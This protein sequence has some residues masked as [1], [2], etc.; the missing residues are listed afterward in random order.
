MQNFPSLTWWCDWTAYSPRQFDW[1]PKDAEMIAEFQDNQLLRWVGMWG[2]DDGLRFRWTCAILA[3]EHW[4][5]E[6]EQLE[7]CFLEMVH[8]KH[9]YWTMFFLSQDLTFDLTTN[10]QWIVKKNLRYCLRIV[11]LDKHLGPAKL[12]VWRRMVLGFL[13]WRSCDGTLHFWEGSCCFFDVNLYGNHV[14]PPGV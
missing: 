8:M 2:V 11:E 5:L 14:K 1:I 6:T 7:I 4:I 3:P 10:S 9:K 12:G 13:N